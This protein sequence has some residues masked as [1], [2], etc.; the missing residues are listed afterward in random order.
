MFMD[1]KAVTQ[2]QWRWEH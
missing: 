1:M 2:H